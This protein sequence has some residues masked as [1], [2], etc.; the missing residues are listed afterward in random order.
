M[1]LADEIESRLSVLV[2]LPLWAVHRAADLECLSFGDRWS[3]S[4]VKGRHA[5]RER[6]IAEYAL[7]FQCAWRFR[8]LNEELVASRDVRTVVKEGESWDEPGANRRD[9]RMDEAIRP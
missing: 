4:E 5:R 2:G 1:S 7:H 9:V 3:M 6:H 8:T